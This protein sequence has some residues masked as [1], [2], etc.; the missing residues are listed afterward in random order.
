MI[1]QNS[2]ELVS[3]MIGISI[4]MEKERIKKKREIELVKEQGRKEENEEG[5][6]IGSI[7]CTML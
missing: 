2:D 5:E 4:E 6:C 3:F 1:C 7:R